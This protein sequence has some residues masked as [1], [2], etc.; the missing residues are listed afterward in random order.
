[1]VTAGSRLANYEI[2]IAGAFYRALFR[3]RERRV[4][5]VGY[6]E[7]RAAMKLSE[8]KE[9]ARYMLGDDNR[10]GADTLAE[11]TVLLVYAMETIKDALYKN[12]SAEFYDY[13][14]TKLAR[15]GLEI[16]K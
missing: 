5:C 11:Q 2:I 1:M 12:P 8:I 16:D 6:A 13:V 10:C 7:R 3:A 9:H 4:Y 15:I 14:I